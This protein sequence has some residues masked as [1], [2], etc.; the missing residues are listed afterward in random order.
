MS[1]TSPA[2]SEPAQVTHQ[3]HNFRTFSDLLL[4][5]W[6]VVLQ[7]PILFIVLPVVVWFPF[8][9]LAEYVALKQGG[10]FISDWRAYNRISRITNFF[11]GGWVNAIL[12]VALYKIAQ[13]KPV[14]L[15][16]VLLDGTNEY[17]RILGVMFS[18]GWRVGLSLILF[19]VPGIVLA[20]RYAFV[21]PIAIFEKK[22]GIEVLEISSD[23]MSGKSW[24]LLLYFLGGFSIYFL[25]ATG[26]IV[27][28]PVQET[29]LLN[30]ITSIPF[31]IIG[32]LSLVALGLLYVDSTG[33]QEFKRPVAGPAKRTAYGMKPETRDGR[34][35]LFAAVAIS[36]LL[37]TSAAYTLINEPIFPGE[38]MAFGNQR[39]EVY[40]QKFIDP[41][42]VEKLGQAL[43]EYGYFESAIPQA[44][45]LTVDE[46]P[47]QAH[48]RQGL[49]VTCWTPW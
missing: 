16:K 21:M 43:K 37:V 4:D 13:S 15:G 30:A 40:F 33:S 23:Y 35:T 1:Q 14:S 46:L 24:R 49:F 34:T 48:L 31:N 7:Y 47:G 11:V 42:E 44:V 45:R 20:L 36:L 3:S 5:V 10:G 27:F 17:G 8:D 18:L 6:R 2:L 22:R 9:L 25:G 29:P 32:T 39:H 41:S 19:I 28:G 26:L 12:F 38:K